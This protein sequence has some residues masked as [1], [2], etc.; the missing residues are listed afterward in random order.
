MEKISLPS[1]IEFKKGGEK[2]KSVLTVEPCFP[3]YGTTLGNALRRVLLSSLPG[4]AITSFKV[5]GAPH[6]FSGLPGI[7]EDLVE[8]IL[9]LKKLRFRTFSE[10][11]VKLQLKAKG[12]RTVLAKDI[13][14][15]SAVESTTPDLLIATL[16]DPTAELVMELTLKNGRGYEPTEERSREERE[17]L[18]VGEITIDAIF[19]PV[20]EV[21]FRIES[22][23]VGQMTNY[24]RL[25]LEIETDGTIT[26][27]QALGGALEILLDHFN[28]LVGFGEAIEEKETAGAIEE[29]INPPAGGAGEPVSAETASE[30][31]G[32]EKKFKKRGRP[33]SRQGG[34]KK[35]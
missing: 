8:I 28:L 5:Q 13:E 6:E 22:V 35:E 18:T 7:K 24:E 16:T 9:N 33:A 25:V 12:E 15:N 30:E 31:I 10:E 20:R 14:P 1:R 4:T 27:E 32:E 17:S 2:N 19:T 34:P 23:R 3:G 29:E 26:P 11:P 21:A